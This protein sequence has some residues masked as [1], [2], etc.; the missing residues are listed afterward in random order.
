MTGQPQSALG[1]IGVGITGRRRHAEAGA[2]LGLVLVGVA[3]RWS[4]ET[5]AALGDVTVFGSL[6]RDL[7][8]GYGLRLG[9]GAVRLPCA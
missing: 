3:D 4:A 2:A 7:R 6:L 5:V 8:I 9:I 1:Q